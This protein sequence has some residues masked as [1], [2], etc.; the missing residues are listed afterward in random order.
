M[1]QQIPKESKILKVRLTICNKINLFLT[2]SKAKQTFEK[3]TKFGRI[4][5][6]LLRIE[7]GQ[8]D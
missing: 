8:C 7:I 1:L 4:N 5:D 6:G 3:P 2:S